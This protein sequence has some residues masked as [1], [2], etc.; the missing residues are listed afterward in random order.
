[1]DLPGWVLE[2]I[3]KFRAPETG[4]V[5]IVLERYND[6]VT[7]AEIGASVRMKRKGVEERGG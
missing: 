2:I 4:K 7:Q 5:T 1:M 6:G 3:K